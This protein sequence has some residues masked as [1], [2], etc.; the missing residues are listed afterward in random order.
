VYFAHPIFASEY[1]A[2]ALYPRAPQHVAGVTCVPEMEALPFEYNGV[3][4]EFVVPR[5]DGHQM[6]ALIF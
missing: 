1:S 6:V 4:V 2:L 5:I 3:G